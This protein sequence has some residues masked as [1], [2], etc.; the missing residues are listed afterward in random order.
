LAFQDVNVLK[1][2]NYQFKNIQFETYCFG[3]SIIIE[4]SN[5]QTFKMETMIAPQ[6]K[7]QFP[8]NNQG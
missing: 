1:F 4:S 3:N 7:H 6:N 2:T 8:S 5:F